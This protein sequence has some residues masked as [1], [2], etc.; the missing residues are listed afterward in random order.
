VI[1]FAV[2]VLNELRDRTPQEA[3]PYKDHPVQALLFD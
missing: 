1:A 2:V 3:L